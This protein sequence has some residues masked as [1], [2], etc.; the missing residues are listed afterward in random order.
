LISKLHFHN[1]VSQPK[2]LL[3]SSAV[4]DC[5]QALSLV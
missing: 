1:K 2:D 5:N 3:D 4:L